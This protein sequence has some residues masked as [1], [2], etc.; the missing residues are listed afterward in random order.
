MDPRTCISHTSM[1]MRIIRL[2]EFDHLF[3]LVNISSL[4]V[5]LPYEL[6]DESRSPSNLVCSSK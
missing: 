4:L 3:S 6:T 1:R 5:T 2:T